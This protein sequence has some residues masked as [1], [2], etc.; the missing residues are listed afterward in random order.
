MARRR[1]P[2][3]A[4]DQINLTPLID[5]VFFLL[6]IFMITAPILEY[7]IDVSVPEMTTTK[8]IEPDKDSKVINI[9]RN[10]DIEFEK[11]I[12]SMQVLLKRLDEIKRGFLTRNA[13]IYLR[14]DADLRY[15]EVIAVMKAIKNAGFEDILLITQDEK[16]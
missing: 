16:K 4:F 5:T 2:S 13:K 1:F 15:G 3:P 6:I 9:K 8:P 10:G 11:Q 12:I 14:G 7:S